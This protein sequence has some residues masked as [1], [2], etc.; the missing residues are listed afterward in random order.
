MDFRPAKRIIDIYDEWLSPLPFDLAITIN[1][2]RAL[3][4]YQQHRVL[5]DVD[6]KLNR[7]FLG[8]RYSLRSEER[9]IRIVGIPV[10]KTPGTHFHWAVQIP[11]EASSHQKK[12][13]THS[14]LATFLAEE[15]QR[16]TLVS[17][18]MEIRRYRDT[19]WLRYILRSVNENTE[20]Y[21]RGI[22]SRG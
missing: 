2:N 20:V 10:D 16:R 12:A 5:R 8:P 9:R 7:V 11:V 6:G 15:A 3:T 4:P 1:A 22:V 19:G 21:V 14:A 17:G 13:R 18:S